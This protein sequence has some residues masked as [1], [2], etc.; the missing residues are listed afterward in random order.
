MHIKWNEM[1][2]RSKWKWDNVKEHCVQLNADKCA[3]PA[4]EEM[5]CKWLL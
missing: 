4:Y 1:K 3:A 5:C 2:N